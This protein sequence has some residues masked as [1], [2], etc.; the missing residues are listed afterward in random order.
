MS[1]DL[2]SLSLIAA[3]AAGDFPLQTD[4]MAAGKFDSPLVRA[5]HVSVYSLPFV[6]ALAGSPW[7]DQQRCTFLT[8]NWLVHFTIDSRRWKAPTEEFET[9]PVWF[10]QA[11]H[12]VSLGVLA[13]LTD[14]MEDDDE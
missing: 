3:H 9:L 12:T 10:D 5:A 7:N 8:G 11:L 14:A 6:A 13:T 2:F 4:A 1:D